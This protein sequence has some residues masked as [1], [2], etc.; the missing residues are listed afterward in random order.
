MPTRSST[1]PRGIRIAG[2]SAGI[3]LA[4]GVPRGV[5]VGIG[6]GLA[7][8]P[9]GAGSATEIG[10]AMSIR[11]AKLNDARRPAGQSSQPGGGSFVPNARKSYLPATGAGVAVA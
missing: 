8:A 11:M 6:V 5:G 7:T 4:L 9:L 10:V 2:Q 1:L 3:P